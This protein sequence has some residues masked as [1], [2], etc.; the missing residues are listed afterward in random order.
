MTNDKPG[1]ESPCLTIIKI[2]HQLPINYPS[3]SPYSAITSPLKSF[4]SA[5][6]C[7]RPGPEAPGST[8]ETRV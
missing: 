1:Y 5:E 8:N 4:H 3:I 6:L 7:N 2:N